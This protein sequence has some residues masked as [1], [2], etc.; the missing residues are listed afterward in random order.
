MVKT[1]ND[2]VRIG[3]ILSTAFTRKCILLLC[4][5]AFMLYCLR[6]EY[7]LLTI[8]TGSILDDETIP[9]STSQAVTPTKKTKTLGRQIVE[10]AFQESYGYLVDFCGELNQP[11]S[12]QACFVRLHSLRSDVNSTVPV[13][14]F[15][16]WF[17]TMIRDARLPKSGI[18]GPW[19]YLQFTADD[20]KA[21]QLCVYEKGGTKTW[22]ILHCKLMEKLGANITGTTAT[23]CYSRQ[24]K[25]L[26]EESIPKSVFLRDPLER[27][28]SGFL[29]KCVDPNN[30][31]TTP[32][33]RPNILFQNEDDIDAHVT[34]FLEDSQTLFQ[35]HMDVSPVC[36]RK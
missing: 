8:D 2:L 33:C 27:Y 22:R 17:Q 13:K 12:L 11:L 35:L 19:H 28:L 10:K 20:P 31:R 30:R 21:M 16:W 24:G 25:W 18:H 15:P 3:A 26:E 6:G 23:T 34:T 32:H 29:D 4:V 1:M 5:T 9:K 14:K 36:R 7:V